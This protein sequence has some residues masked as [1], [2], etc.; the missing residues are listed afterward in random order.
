MDFRSI[1][2]L[3]LWTL[4]S[5]PIFNAPSGSSSFAARKNAPVKAA[6]FVKPLAPR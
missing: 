2:I 4:I 3:A 1:A 5:G 6:K